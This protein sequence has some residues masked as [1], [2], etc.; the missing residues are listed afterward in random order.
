MEQSRRRFIGAAAVV[1]PS[2]SA[3][4]APQSYIE[5][6]K[7]GVLEWLE[8]VRSKDEGWGRWKYTRHMERKYGL[9]STAMAIGALHML[10]ELKK[11]PAKWKQEAVTFYQSCQDPKDGYFKDPLVT[12]KDRISNQHSWEH[13]WAQM[14]SISSAL[15]LLGAEPLHKS[16]SNRFIATNSIPP[17]KWH[18]QFDWKNPWLVGEE[19]ARAVKGFWSGLPASEKKPDHPALVRAF[20][21]M[22]RDVID[23]ATGFPTKGGCTN[24][25]VAMAGLFKV[26]SA[27]LDV[28]RP[29]P[30]PE[31]SIDSVLKLQQPNGE[32]GDRS[33]MCYNWDSLWLLRVLDAQIKGKHRH[34]DI[35]SAAD[36]N[37]E[38]LIAKYRKPD[39][40]FTRN[41][42]KC[43]TE[44]NSIRVG[45]ALVEGDMLGT[46]FC[47]E[48]FDYLD[49]WRGLRPKRATET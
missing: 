16:P 22:E 7:P 2:W 5:R 40:G 49:E 11:A 1:A 9:Q 24:M 43:M 4:G 41:G 42:D 6:V 46:K 21:A 32:F 10:G 14:S 26:A 33:E 38:I 25:S 36:R 28:R 3:A 8:S 12:E 30:N 31:R 15:R 39:G 17:E 34:E 45:P 47:L 44:H 35:V 19:W 37:A 27:Y 13:I 18:L 20:A 23:P 48:C 29:V